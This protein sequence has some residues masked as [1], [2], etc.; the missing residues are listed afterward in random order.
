MKCTKCNAEINENIKFCSECGTKVVDNYSANLAKVNHKPW[1]P[2]LL[3]IMPLIWIIYKTQIIQGDNIALKVAEALGGA[4]AIAILPM[5]ISFI[6][7]IINRRKR[8]H[9]GNFV[10]HTFL[11]MIIFSFFIIGGEIN[12]YL[13]EKVSMMPSKSSITKSGDEYYKLSRKAFREKDYKKSIEYTDKLIDIKDIRGEYNLGV[14]Y[15]LGIDR[16]KDYFKTFDYMQKA[17]NGKF[18]K[19]C[20]R[21]GLLYREGEGTRQDY[22]KARESFE[23][24]CDGG[25]ANGCLTLGLMYYDGEGVRQDFQKA[26]V[27]FGKACDMKDEDGCE[28]YALLKKDLGR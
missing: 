1:N 22:T 18:L 19:G 26:L 14:L 21:L 10:K 17:C 7:Y 5:F 23:I 6:I 13:D 4:L 9:Y 2:I 16:E 8:T 24:S 3:L 15:Y 11:G 12:T 25:I 27:L 28:I 20:E